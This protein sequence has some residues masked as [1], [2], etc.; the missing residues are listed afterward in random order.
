VGWKPGHYLLLAVS[1]YALVVTFAFSLRGRQV[2][3]LRQEAMAY[4]ERAA[5]APEG[6]ML[7]LP[8]ACLPSLPENLPGAP[9]PYRKGVS[10]GFVF[11]QGDA[12]VPVVRGMGVVAAFGGEVVKVDPDFQELSEEAWQALLERVR[13]GASPEEM[14]ILRGLEVHVRH[15]DGRTTVYAHLQAPYPGLKVG[16]RVHRRDPIGYV[17]NTGLRG[18]ASR[19]LFEVW[20]GEP[21]RSAFLFQG[22][23]GEEL[24]R[25]AR[26]FFGL[27]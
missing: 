23:E 8:G 27:P 9:R 22:L 5:W 1:L 4:R 18:G 20:E 2:A 17:G 24:L 25:R 16:S 6:Y 10:A 15:P 26:A 7:P 11:R 12:C 3:A 19:L 13:E 21:D 14:D